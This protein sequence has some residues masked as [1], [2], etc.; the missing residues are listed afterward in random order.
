MTLLKWK[1]YH[2]LHLCLRLVAA[3]FGEDETSTKCTECGKNLD[4]NC[5]TGGWSRKSVLVWK[6]GVNENRKN[7]PDTFWRVILQTSAT[8]CREKERKWRQTRLQDFKASQQQKWWYHELQKEIKN[9]KFGEKVQHS[10][11]QHL[12]N[13]YWTGHCLHDRDA[14]KLSQPDLLRS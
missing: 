13:T 2:W 8:K 1:A 14:R 7:T 10:F 11:V 4:Y 12:L 6:S 5:P 3:R 9:E